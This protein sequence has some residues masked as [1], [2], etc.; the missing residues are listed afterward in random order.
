M[1][2]MVTNKINTSA[3]SALSTVQSIAIP[4]E[5]WIEVNEEISGRHKKRAGED[6][7]PFSQASPRGVEPLLQDRKS[8]VLTTR[9]WGHVAFTAG[10]YK[11]FLDKKQEKN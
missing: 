5:I 6:P 4:G 8:W 9:R 1:A 2:R 3:I 7:V 10:K 11:E